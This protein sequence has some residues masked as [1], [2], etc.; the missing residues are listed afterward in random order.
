[1][2]LLQQMIVLFILMLLGYFARKRDKISDET[3]KHMSWI[4]VNIA[5]PAMILN[6]SVNS[7][8][9]IEGSELLMTM[10]LAVTIFAV[11]I[12]LS[13]IIPIILRVPKKSA[14]VYRVM[15]I[16][17]NIGFMGFPVISAL[18]GNEALLY[19]A[20][21]QIPFNLLI[22]TYGI[23]ALKSGDGEKEKLDLRKVLNIGVFSCFISIF[24]SFV[25]IP[26]P[27]YIK[28]TVSMLS[29]LTAPLS[30]MV[31]GASM[32]TIDIK[33]LF[34]DAKLLL[35]AAL[36]LIII[37]V[38]GL[39]VLKMFIQNEMRLQGYE[40]KNQISLEAAAE[41]LNVSTDGIDF[42]TAK[43]DSLVCAYLL[44]KCYNKE[45]FEA[46]IK[47]AGNPDFLKRLKF[48]AYA[49]SKINDKC[50]DKK[51][52]IFNCPEC[53]KKAKQVS[54]WKY[55]NRW[56]WANFTC[57][58]GKKFCGRVSFKKTFDD[59]IVRRNVGEFK[60]KKTKT[61]TAQTAVVGTGE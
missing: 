36:K 44:K 12:V 6:G 23:L 1:M 24:L 14:G 22:Y 35:F 13:L 40:D 9:G 49:I 59:V 10:G 32:A 52:L 61:N 42:H 53:N 11:L 58:C 60:I 26:M 39:F 8:K 29:N 37:P 47:D 33:K 3:C 5:N 45:R 17:S 18:Y 20:V 19:A 34:M 7:E 25:Q 48:K 4:V 50:I 41:K 31:I 21:F 43:D 46:L 15:T 57:S 55:Q 28:T 30:M 16:F 56:F 27:S 54:K 38:A 51:H 2:L